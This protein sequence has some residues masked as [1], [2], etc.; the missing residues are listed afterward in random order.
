MNLADIGTNFLGK[1]RFDFSRNNIPVSE[2]D[3]YIELSGYTR[4]GDINFFSVIYDF[5]V[6]IYD[7]LASDF[8][9][10]PISL[11]DFFYI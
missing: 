7:N 3:I 5:P 6:P 4:N 10:H 8:D 11:E 1:V 2:V 9:D